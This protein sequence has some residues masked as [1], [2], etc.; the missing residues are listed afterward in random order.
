MTDDEVISLYSR[1][2]QYKGGPHLDCD[3]VKEINLTF[4]L[5]QSYTNG[6]Y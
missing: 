6:R 5:L 1:S 2:V 4:S 3:R